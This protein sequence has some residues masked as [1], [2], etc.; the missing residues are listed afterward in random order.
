V[1]W[2]SP[3]RHH[4]GRVRPGTR[5]EG[6]LVGQALGGWRLTR[7]EGRAAERDALLQDLPR[8]A[9]FHYAGHAAVAGPSSVA[10]ALITAGGARIE[11]GDLLALPRIPDVVILSACAAA[12]SGAGDT[13]WSSTMGLAQ[14]FL[15]AGARSVV[16]PTRDVS[17]AEARTFMATFYQS[18]GASGH[19]TLAEA[20][21]RAAS[22]AAGTSAQ[23]FRLIVQ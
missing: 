7:L 11:L 17:D 9:L 10:S 20:F 22:A 12:A 13:A 2:P 14:A 15:A 19:A 3:D 23:S 5:S 8:V 21:R 16:A 6:D 4:G 18:Y 1:A